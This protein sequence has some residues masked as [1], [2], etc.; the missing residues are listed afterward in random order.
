MRDACE[1]EAVCEWD[2]NKEPSFQHQL[3]G[4]LIID[5]ILLADQVGQLVQ[6]GILLRIQ[7]ATNLTYQVQPPIQGATRAAQMS[8]EIRGG[9]KK[10][11]QSLGVEISQRGRPRGWN[12][13]ER[14]LLRTQ[15]KRAQHFG[16]PIERDLA[17][18]MVSREGSTRE[19]HQPAIP[20]AV[21]VTKS[22]ARAVSNTPEGHLHSIWSKNKNPVN[23]PT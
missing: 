11:R 8:G 4:S 7:E 15:A 17:T 5:G 21:T 6:R 3:K 22:S 16:N 14:H 23:S 19:I 20:L 18:A 9:G 2:V 1:K 10:I 13:L 12:R